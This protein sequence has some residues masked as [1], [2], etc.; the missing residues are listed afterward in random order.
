MRGK[1][2]KPPQLA[3]LQLEEKGQPEEKTNQAYERLGGERGITKS[4]FS[5]MDRTLERHNGRVQ[6]SM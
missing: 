4:I 2:S 1:T 3:G 6:L 5:Q